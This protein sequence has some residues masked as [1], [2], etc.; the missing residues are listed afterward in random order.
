MEY[1]FTYATIHGPEVRRF[2]NVGSLMAYLSGWCSKG[3]S[4]VMVV[5]EF[6]VRG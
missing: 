1:V 4:P 5:S 3:T 6:E 2:W